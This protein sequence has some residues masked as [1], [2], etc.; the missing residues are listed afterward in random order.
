MIDDSDSNTE[1]SGPLLRRPGLWVFVLLLIAAAE[2]TTIK[3]IDACERELSSQTNVMGVV[4]NK[5]RYMG[6]DYGYGY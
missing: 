4:L 6:E 5:C 1:S 2:K 3:E